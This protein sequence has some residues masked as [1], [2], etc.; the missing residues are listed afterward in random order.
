MENEIINLPASTGTAL[1]LIA[2]GVIV[3]AFTSL[4]KYEG[5]PKWLKRVIPIVLA[6]LAAVLIVILQGGGDLAD[7]LTTWILVAATVV[8]IAQTVYSL[9]PS[10]WKRLE[11]AT[12]KATDAPEPL[13]RPQGETQGTGL[14]NPPDPRV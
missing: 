13:D 3:P 8:G 4:F 9:M 12:Q 11:V 7:K 10:A 6:A 5:M 2:S 1:A 14:G